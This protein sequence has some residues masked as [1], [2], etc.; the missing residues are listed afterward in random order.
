MLHSSYIPLPDAQE[1]R[2]WDAAATTFGLPEVLL[3]ENAARAALAVLEDCTGPVAG[4]RVWLVMGGGNNG[5][6]AAC[7]ARLLLDAEALPLVIHTKVLR[8]LSGAAARHVRWARKAG[9]PFIAA[10]RHNWTDPAPTAP[11]QTASA[12]RAYAADVPQ[13]RD[14]WPDILVDGM[15]GTG[16]SGQLRADALALVRRMNALRH[17]TFLL[18]LDVPSGLNAA[19]GLP[20]PEAVRAHATVTFEAAKPGLVLPQARP[21]TGRL[22]APRI[23]IPRMVRQAHAPTCY[24]VD[25][26]CAVLLPPP[27][28]H[29]YKGSFGHVLVAGGAEGMS[30]AAHLAARAVLR[31]GGG[32]VTAA[33]PACTDVRF[34]L[35]DI[36][37]LP[38]APASEPASALAGA[39]AYPKPALSPAPQPPPCGWP[40]PL[41]DAL[42]SRMAACAAL[43][44]GPGM[45]RTADGAAFLRAL[46]HLPQR[47]AAVI[48]ADALWHVAQDEQLAALLRPDDI[49]TP[50]A[51]EAAR[52]LELS[53]A[54][55]Q[56]DRRAALSALTT[57]FPCVCVL[58]GAGTLISRRDA[59]HILAPFDAPNLA[60]AGSGD[61][62]AGCIGAL[63]AQ[64]LD[65][66]N[67]AAL[68]VLLHAEAGLDLREAFPERGNLSSQTADTLPEAR[69]RLCGT[70]GKPALTKLFI[71]PHPYG[72]RT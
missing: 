45:G 65:S 70:A 27:A 16:F 14:A 8:T 58:K 42:L 21:F 69:A 35:P 5:G 13:A 12:L 72:S 68:G 63:L 31:A 7:L 19:S 44:I 39:Q 17:D 57:R 47:P 43:V 71:H 37:T 9:V 49:L 50:H 25:A 33:S 52:L 51:G 18:A 30:G 22:Y 55:V 26:G 64:G 24:A 4:K 67:A 6:D 20:M 29:T 2:A 40:A 41:P 59:P 46:L 34:G 23:G 38:L 32:L 28:C 56:Q 36:M 15:L 62:L 1:M 60:L 3:M 53:S 61:V 11:P 66:L 10:A 48:D 54:D